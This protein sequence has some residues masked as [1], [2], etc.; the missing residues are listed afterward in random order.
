M[1]L[2]FGRLGGGIDA[3][4][5]CAFA[6]VHS[7]KSILITIGNTLLLILVSF[8]VKVL[9]FYQLLGVELQGKVLL[10]AHDYLLV[11]GAFELLLSLYCD[12]ITIDVRVF[13]GQ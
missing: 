3:V 10:L 8:E 1:R 9:I 11:D 12:D 6:V 2:A 13:E 5:V 4:V 7:L